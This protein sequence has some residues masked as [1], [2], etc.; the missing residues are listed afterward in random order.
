[1]GNKRKA[2]T[3]ENPASVSRKRAK[4]ESKA[5]IFKQLDR[6]HPY[7][8][9]SQYYHYVCTLRQ[10]LANNFPSSHPRRRQILSYQ[11]VT[12]QSLSQDGRDDF[13]DRVMVGK[14]QEPSQEVDAAREKEY[15]AFTQSQQKSTSSTSSSQCCNMQDVGDSFFSLD[16]GTI[17]PSANCFYQHQPLLTVLQLVNFAIWK[18]SRSSKRSHHIL[19]NGKENQASGYGMNR[20]GSGEWSPKPRVEVYGQAEHERSLKAEPW[21]TIVHLLGR[22]GDAIMRSLLLDCGVFVPLQAGKENFYQLSGKD[23]I[24]ASFGDI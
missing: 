19:L 22:R 13:L 11:L 3:Y 17:F 20:N 9:L 16:C 7:S 12:E 4:I 24:A 8:L 15:A 23:R 14:L 6:S 21:N 1:M 5:P 10:Y 18:L 2:T